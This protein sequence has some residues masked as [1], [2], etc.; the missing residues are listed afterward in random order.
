MLS[1]RG[2]MFFF[3][4]VS[5][6]F[7]EQNSSSHKMIKSAPYYDFSQ[8]SNS[9]SCKTTDFSSSIRVGTAKISVVKKIS[10]RDF[11]GFC[12]QSPESPK[13][14]KS[15]T[16]IPFDQLSNFVFLSCY[17]IDFLHQELN[18]N[19]NISRRNFK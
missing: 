4:E 2:E 3:Q 8:P 17:K 12:Y 19:S 14:P 9:Y 16:F 7:L 5:T 10:M 15:T 6:L 1:T 11:V 13:L 18:L